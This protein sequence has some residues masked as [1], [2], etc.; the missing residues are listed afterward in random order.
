MIGGQ[1]S[2]CQHS[3]EIARSFQLPFSQ[4]VVSFLDYD[5]DKRVEAGRTLRRSRVWGVSQMTM[6]AKKLH[7]LKPASLTICL[8]SIMLI[9]KTR[10]IICKSFN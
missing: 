4:N 7:A 8:T 2:F 6:L 5:K 1:W 9:K 10:F 3:P